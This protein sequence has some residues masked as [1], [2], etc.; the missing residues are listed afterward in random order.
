VK[1]VDPKK[2]RSGLGRRDAVSGMLHGHVRWPNGS[3]ATPFGCR[4][5]GW[6]EG[7]HGGIHMPG[8]G[9]H[10][11]E[12]PTPA[13]ILARMKAR[14]EARKSV[15]RCPDPNDPLFML[16]Q[17]FAPVVDPWKCEANKCRMH[18]YLVGLWLTPVTGGVL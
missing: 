16:P 2:F 7:V 10:W 3:P 17:P 8:R 11:W 1:L 13:Q 15:C 5:C 12:Q 18:D 4:W 9:L 6:P 14:R